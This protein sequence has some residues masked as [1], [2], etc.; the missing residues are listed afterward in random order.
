LQSRTSQRNGEYFQPVVTR[1]SIT[2]L[3]DTPVYGYWNLDR[4]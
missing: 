1:K 4:K 2:G 3:L